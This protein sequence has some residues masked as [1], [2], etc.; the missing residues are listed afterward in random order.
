MDT[1]KFFM[2]AA[3]AFNSAKNQGANRDLSNLAAGLIEMS[4]G[5]RQLALQVHN[6]EAKLEHMDKSPE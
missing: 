2:D 5:L 6:I 4:E 3:S 1:S